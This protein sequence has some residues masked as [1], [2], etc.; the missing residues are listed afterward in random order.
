MIGGFPIRLAIFATHPIQYQV[1]LWRR[2]AGGGLVHPV[3]HYF[4]DVGVAEALD[5]D[6]GVSVRWDMPLL[7][8]Y[9][10]TFVSRRPSVA[11]GL[12]LRL[13]DAK[14]TLL[15]GGYDAVMVAGYVHAFEWQ[16]TAAARRLGLGVL[17]RGEFSDRLAARSGRA[18]ATLRDAVLRARYRRVDAFCVIGAEARSHLERLAVPSEKLFFSPYCVDS[19]HFET[20]A[21]TTSRAAS[22]DALGLKGDDF[23]VL[24]SG[25]LIPRKGVDVLAAAARQLAASHPRVVFL[26]VGDGPLRPQLESLRDEL[27]ARRVTLAGFVNQS[28]L[29]CYFAAADAFVLPSRHETWGLVVNEAMYFGLPVIVTDQVG[30]A[31]DLVTP[32]TGLVVPVSRPDALASAISRLTGNVAFARRLG[33]GGRERIKTYSV[34][35]AARGI[36]QAAVAAV[37]RRRRRKS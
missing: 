11:P 13:S 34:D 5:P 16:A 3:V 26:T 10:S 15:R 35:N 4:S 25:K 18:R 9:E 31:A 14:R 27:S 7:D 2:L 1:P 29:G 37:A 21:A 19:S 24:F 32:E 6:F 8:G 23:V 22:R 28:E 30:C 20:L 36:E 12:S 33:S 17:M